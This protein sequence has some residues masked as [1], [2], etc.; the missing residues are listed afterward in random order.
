MKLFYSE[1]SL[2]AENGE[3]IDGIMVSDV[4]QV[5]GVAVVKFTM[6]LEDAPELDDEVVEQAISGM[7]E[8]LAT[9]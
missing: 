1:G 4:E 8:L 5:E 3:K 7:R 9:P 2:I 6:L